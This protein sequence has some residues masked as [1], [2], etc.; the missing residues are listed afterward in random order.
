MKKIKNDKK[1]ANKLIGWKVHDYLNRGKHTRYETKQYDQGNDKP[2]I[3]M[4]RVIKTERVYKVLKKASKQYRV[5]KPRYDKDQEIKRI[6]KEM[7]SE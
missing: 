6:L 3:T 1:M 5:W 2:I 4:T 7:E